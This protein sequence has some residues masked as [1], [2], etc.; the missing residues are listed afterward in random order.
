VVSPGTS[1]WRDPISEKTQHK[2]RAGGVAQGVRV[3]R[4]AQGPEFK[5]KDVNLK[6]DKVTVG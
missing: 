6:K 1:S 2:K 4:Q 5:R 3:P